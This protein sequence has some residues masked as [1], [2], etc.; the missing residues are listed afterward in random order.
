VTEHEHK[1]SEIETD[2][3]EL[4]SRGDPKM[5]GSETTWTYK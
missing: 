4:T 2:K 1:D 5:T 3:A